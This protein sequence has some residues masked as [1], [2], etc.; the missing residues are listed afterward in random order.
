MVAPRVKILPTLRLG[1]EAARARGFEPSLHDNIP[2]LLADLAASGV[3]EALV[4]CGP[5]LLAAF[6]EAGL[7]DEQVVIRQA[8]EAGQADQVDILTRIPFRV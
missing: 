7:W 6:L 1:A 8:A 2:A 3:L 5:A 4:E